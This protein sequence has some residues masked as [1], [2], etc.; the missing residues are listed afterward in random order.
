MSLKFT[1]KGVEVTAT[2]AEEAAALIR[3]LSAD[4]QPRREKPKVNGFRSHAVARRVHPKGRF[5]AA[6]A[7][8]D[9]LAA[10]NHGGK[11]G[12]MVD[13]LMP[14]L[15]ADHPKGVGARLAKI[16]QFLSGLGFDVENVYM[17]PRTAEG[18]VWYAGKN[19]E[20]ALEAARKATRG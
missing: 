3:A 2:S 6:T 18:R 1:I 20:Q 9:V 19:I 17:N 10:I 14:L 11:E 13:A 7:A 8:V 16:N 15:H 12:I 5:N 4:E